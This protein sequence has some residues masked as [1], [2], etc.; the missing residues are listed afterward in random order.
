[1]IRESAAAGDLGGSAGQ[2][3]YTAAS[4]AGKMMTDVRV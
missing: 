1:M 2:A 4:P 3:E